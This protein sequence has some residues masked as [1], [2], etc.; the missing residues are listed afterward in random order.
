MDTSVQRTGSRE[1]WVAFKGTGAFDSQAAFEFQTD[2]FEN[3]TKARAQTASGSRKSPSTLPGK[4]PNPLAYSTD[5]IFDIG[6][7]GL[8][9]SSMEPPSNDEVVFRK[10]VAFKHTAPIVPGSYKP[11]QSGT[12]QNSWAKPSV[13]AAV[14]D[15]VTVQSP[16]QSA[17]ISE[18]YTMQGVSKTFGGYITEKA[19]READAALRAAERRARKKKTGEQE[20]QAM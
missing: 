7:N 2:S 5:D 15:N 8:G 4:P 12:A 1:G 13:S 20:S 18:R 10:D 17:F 6:V 9:R 3:Y 16:L 11:R 14:A 19:Q